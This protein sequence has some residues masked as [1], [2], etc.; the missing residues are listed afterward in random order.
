MFGKFMFG[1]MLTSQQACFV[2]YSQAAM[3]FNKNKIL[4]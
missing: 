1:A 2:I 3:L 4:I